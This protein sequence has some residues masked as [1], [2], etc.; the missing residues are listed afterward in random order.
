MPPTCGHKKRFS[1]I[2]LKSQASSVHK[3]RI[4]IVIRI[5]NV[6]LGNVTAVGSRI[7]KSF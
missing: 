3:K 7:N 5:F 1:R 2:K 6:D 4:A